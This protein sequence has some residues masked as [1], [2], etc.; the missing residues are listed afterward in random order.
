[1]FPRPQRSQ[2]EFPMSNG[3]THRVYSLIPK[4][5]DDGKPAE[6]FWHRIGS[7]FAHKDAK[8]F[9]IV[10]ESLPL[11]GKLVM[12]EITDAEAEP[13]PQKGKGARR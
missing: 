6:P 9:N 12:R 2:L 4:T 13:E 11:D 10:L 3:P 5:G 8:G 7:C 1:M